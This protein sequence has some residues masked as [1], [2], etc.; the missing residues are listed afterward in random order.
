MHLNKHGD[1]GATYNYTIADFQADMQDMKIDGESV[2]GKSNPSMAVTEITN[3][4]SNNWWGY[5]YNKNTKKFRVTL[6]SFEESQWQDLKKYMEWSGNVV[7]YMGDDLSSAVVIG[8]EEKTYNISDALFA[9]F[10][11]P[12]IS[13]SSSHFNG[14]GNDSLTL[15]I[16]ATDKYYTPGQS[17]DANKIMLLVDNEV[18]DEDDGVTI[19][20]GTPEVLIGT[21]NG[22]DSQYGILQDVTITGLSQFLGRGVK[23]RLSEDTVHDLSGNKNVPK[24]ISLFNTLRVAKSSSGVYESSTTSGFLGN[25]SIQRQNIQSVTFLNST[26]TAPSTGT[27]D[28]SATEDN[29]IIAW[30]SN[31]KV[32]I[33][34]D[35]PIYANVDSSYLF[36]YIGYASGVTSGNTIENLDLLSTT[37]TTNMQYMFRG[38][39]YETMTSFA[40]GDNFETSRVTNMEGM[41]QDAGNKLTS[42]TIGQRFETSNVSNMKNMFNN[43]GSTSLTTLNLGNR[44]TTQNV[45]NMDSMFYNCGKTAMTE[46]DLGPAFTKI[47]DAHTNIFENTGK[48]GA[49]IF[50]GSAIYLNKKAFRLNANST[51]TTGY[52]VGTVVPKYK[53]IWSKTDVTFDESEKSLT[54]KVAGQVDSS[55]YG[56][57]I[58]TVTNNLTNGTADANSTKPFNVK[59]AGQEANDI[60]KKVTMSK[61]GPSSTV[62]A[63]IILTDFEQSVLQSGKSYLE[64]S[65]KTALQIAEGTLVDAY[66][67]PNLTQSDESGTMTAI[68]IKDADSDTTSKNTNG[69]MFADFV[70]PATMYDYSK[71]TINKTSKTV[72]I[73]FSI[74]DKYFASENLGIEIGAANRMIVSMDGTDLAQTHVNMVLAKTPITESGATIGYKY[75]LTLTELEQDAI[76]VGKNYLDYSG[77]V[78]ITI[79]KGSMTDKSGNTNPTKPLSV[80]PGN[81]ILKPDENETTNIDLVNPTW[82]ADSNN[83]SFDFTTGKATVIVKATDKYFKSSTLTS[84][85]ITVYLGNTAVTSG[86]TKTVSAATALKETR[87]VNGVATEVQ[88]GN[89]YTVT[90]TGITLDSDQGKL[91]IAAGTATDTSGNTSEAKDI[92]LYNRLKS[93]STETSATSSFLGND[94]TKIPIQRQNIENVTFESYISSD[95]YN[96]TTNKITDETR[97]WDVSAAGDQ[98]IIAW[99]EETRTG[100]YIVH[101]GS[102]GGIL[103]NRT[104][105]NLFKYIGYSNKCQETQ[106]IT[107]I[108]L[109]DVSSVTSMKNMFAYTGYNAMT[110]LDLGTNFDTSK[111][112]NM[113]GMFTS[114][115]ENAMTTLNLQNKFNTAIVTDMSNM[116]ERTG[117]KNLQSLDVSKFNTSAV[118][119]M[120]YMFANT[121]AESQSFKTLDLSSFNTTGVTQMQYMFQNTGF[122]EMTSLNLGSAFNTAKVT[123]MSY[124]FNGTASSKMTKLSLEG[125]FYTTAVTN[126]TSMFQNCG[127]GSMTELDLGPAFTKISGK[128]TDIFAECGQQENIKIYVGSSIYSGQQELRLGADSSN[129]ISFTR[130]TIIPKYRPQWIALTTVPDKANS[131][132]TVTLKGTVNSTNYAG[133]NSNVTNKF[134]NT[135][136]SQI[137]VSIDGDPD[138]NSNITKT[139]SGASATPESNVQCSL[140]LTGFKGTRQASKK[141]TEWS[142]N[143]A[144]EI[145]QATLVDS[146]G[147]PNLKLE[148]DKLQDSPTGKANATGKLF[149]D[150][151]APEFTYEH[152]ETEINHK[153]KKVT[154]YFSVTDK[155]FNKI[156]E[157]KLPKLADGSYNSSSIAL[158]LLDTNTTI[159]NDAIKK[160]LTRDSEIYETINGQ[161]QKVGEKFKLVIEGLD[162][163]DG[164]YYS[165]PMAIAL[166]E[167]MAEDY[168]GTKSSAKTITIGVDDPE[169][170]TNHKNQEIVD[171]VSPIW[172]VQNMNI[173]QDA[174]GK[175]N[176]TMEL[177]GKDKYLDK[178]RSKELLTSNS[179]KVMVD[180]VDISGLATELSKSLSEPEEIT[181]GLKYTLTISNLEESYDAFI[182]ARNEGKRVYREYSGDVS[183]EIPEETL[184]DNYG[185]KSSK[186]TIGVGEI[187]TLKPEIVK[188]SSSID[189]TAKTETIVF[190]VTD[191]YYSTILDDQ[192]LLSKLHVFIDNENADAITKQITN[193]ETLTA[194]IDGVERTVGKRYTLVLSDFEQAGLQSGYQFKGLS[195]TVK[196]NVDAGIATDTKGNTSDVTT[197]QGDF[198]D[199]I[200]P[201][202]IYKYT[203]PAE[204]AKS[205]DIVFDVTDKYYSSGDLTLADLT[206]KMQN[207]T[208]L[209]NYIDMK[210]IPGAKLTLST[211]TNVVETKAMNKTV[212]GEVKTGLTNQVVGRR[213]T[214]T[215]SGLEQS[216]IATGAKYLEYS[217][218]V[219]IA[220]AAGKIKD[221]SNNG[222]LNKTLTFGIDLPDETGT[223]E[224]LDIV[225]P[226]WAVDSQTVDLDNQEA[227]IVVTATDKYFRES[228]LTNETLELWINGQQVEKN[229][230]T[231]RNLMIEKQEEMYEDWIESGNTSKHLVGVKYTIKV[232]GFDIDEGQVKIKIPAGT[233]K[234]YSG[235]QSKELEFLLYSCLK[236]TNT[237][238]SETSGF[239]G[240]TSIQRQNIESVTFV[241]GLSTANNTKWDVSAGNDGSIMAWYTTN[242]SNGA[243]D[244]Y[245]GGTAAIFANPNS[246]YLFANIGSASKCTAT[247]VIKGLDLVTTKRV[248]NMKY[249]FYNTGSNAMTKL[250]LG[251]NFN[252]ESAKDMSHMFDGCGKDNMSTLK[253]N[254]KF[255]TTQV[256]DMSYM[257]ANA[258]SKLS[259]LDVSS[260][261][262]TKVTQMQ[263]M[264]QNTGSNKLKSLNLGDNFNT[265][266][267]IDM[268]Y[269]FNGTANASSD[270]TK[271]SLGKQFYTTSVTN[272]TSMFQDCGASHMTE[273]DLGPVFTK[274]A[275]T[276]TNMFASAEKSSAMVIDAPEAIYQD[277]NNFRLGGEGSTAIAYSRG[278]INPKYRTEWAIESTTV[279][280]TTKKVEITLRGKINSQITAA[281]YPAD[282]VTGIADKS[283]IKVYIDGNELENVEASMD[284][285]DASYR[286]NDSGRIEI[287]QTIT[288]TDFE[289]TARQSG[290]SYKE[291]S[292]NITLKILQDS[293]LVDDCGD[294]TQNVVGNQNIEQTFSNIKIVDFIKP[295]LTYKYSSTDIS[296]TQKTLTVDF[297]VVDKYFA[298]SSISESDITV[299]MADTNAEPSNITKTLTKVED[300]N[301]IRDN[302]TVT[303]GAKYRLVVSGLEQAVKTADAKYKDYSGPI[304]IG[305]A[306]G[307]VKDT[308]DNEN[309]PMSITVGVDEPDKS[310]IQEKVD[311]VDPIWETKNINIDKTNKK[312]TVDLYGTDKYYRSDTLDISKI[313]VFVDGTEITNSE[314][315]KKELSEPEI[316]TETREGTTTQYGVKY[317]LTLSGWAETNQEFIASKRE[318]REY[319]GVTKIRIAENTLFDEHNANKQQEFTLGTVDFINPDIIYEYS[320][321]TIDYTNK[322]LNVVFS[323]TDK[324]Y[325][326]SASSLALSDLT[327]T[328]DGKAMTT[329]QLTASGN[330]L[331]GTA[332]DSGKGMKYTLT[333]KNL[334]QNPN[335]GMNFS[336]IVSIAIP[337][338]KFADK[339][340]N[341]NEAKTITIGV[342][343][344]ENDANHNE[345]TVVDVVDP[346]WKVG[347]VTVDE[348]NNRVVVEL[349]GSDKYLDVDNSSLVSNN[350]KVYINEEDIESTA[351]IKVNKTLSDKRVEINSETGAFEVIYTLILSNFK[352]SDEDFLSARKAE[353]RLYREY[354]GN[355][356]IEIPANQLVDTSGNKNKAET[357]DLGK[358]DNIKPDVVKVSSSVDKTNKKE[359]IVFDVVDKYLQSTVLGTT[360]AQANNNLSKLHVYVDDESAD[361]ITKKITNVE[362]KTSTIGGKTDQ[363]VGYRYTLEVTGFDK[364][365]N[366]K[367]YKDWSGTVSI[368][369]DEG[370][371]IDSTN[372]VNEAVTLQGDFVDFTNPY[373][374]YTHQSSDINTANKTYTMKFRIT[375]K[376]YTSGKLTLDNLTV[377]IK[378]GQLKNGSEIEYNL[379]ELAK[380]GTVTMSLSS[381]ELNATNV[382][383]TNATTGEIENVETTP[384]GHE[385]TLI[386]SNLEK[387][388]IEEGMTTADYSGI[389]TVGIKGDIIKDRTSGGSQNGN[390]GTSITSGIDIPG[391]TGNGT[392]VD[393]V[394]PL[395]TGTGTVADPAQGTATLNF[396]ATDTYFKSSSITATNIKVFVNGEEKAVGVASGD[397]ITKTLTKADLPLETRIEN[398]KTTSRKYGET[399]T[400]NITGYPSNINQLKVIIPAGLVEDNYDNSNKEKVFNL[401]NTLKEAEPNASETSAFLGNTYGIQR[402]KI[403]QI[404]FESYI[405]GET[406]KRWDV[407][408]QQDGSIMA[409]YNTSEISNGTY[410]IHIGSDTLIGAN[411]NSSNWFSY[412]GKNTACTATNEESNPIIKNISSVRFASVKNMSNMFAYLGYSNMTTFSL[413]N[414]FFTTKAENMSGMFSNTGFSKMQSINLGTNFNTS[415]VQ[416][417]TSMFERTGYTAMTSLNLGSKFIINTENSVVMNNMFAE[418]GYTN[419]TSLT[420]GTQFNT[421]TVTS[422]KGMFKSTGN[423][424][425]TSLDLGDLFYTTNVTDMTD[426]FNGCGQDLMATLDLGPAFTKIAESNTN[427][428]TNLGKSGCVVYAPEAIYQDTKNFRLGGAGSTA[429]AYSKTIEPKYRTEWKLKTTTFDKATESLTV[430][431]TGSTNSALATTEYKSNVSTGIT[432]KAKVKVFID[433]TE[434][435]GLNMELTA[436]QVDNTTKGTKDVEQT[437]KITN[438]GNNSGNITLKV[439]QDSGLKDAYGIGSQNIE[440]SFTTTVTDKNT[441]GRLF[442]D[443]VKPE[444]KYV[445]APANID[446]TN[447]TLTV[448]FSVTDKYFASSTLITNTNG[449]LTANQT[450]VNKIT[451]AMKDNANSAVNS[452]VTKKITEI[453]P[454]QGTVDGKTVTTGYKFKLVI[455]GL[456]QE[457]SNGNYRDYS[458][459]MSISFPAGIGTDKSTNTSE[460]K[461]ITIGV[462]TD[463]SGNQ[464]NVDVVDPVWKTDNFSIDNTNKKITVDLIG[465]DKYI[466]TENSNLTTNDITVTVDGEEASSIKKEL[467]A[468]STVSYGIKYTLTLSGWEQSSLQD[469]KKFLEWSGTT[470]IKIASGTLRDLPQQDLPNT[471]TKKYNTSKE[472]TFTLG[473]VDFIKPKIEIASATKNATAGTE[474]IVINA[475]DK[476]IDT[477]NS[478]LTVEDISVYVDNVS[479]TGLTK[480]LTKGTDLTAT[481][482]GNT[483]TIGQQYTLVLSNFKQTRTSIDSAKNYSEWSGTVSIDVAEGKIKDTNNTPNVN[484]KIDKLAVDFVDFI[485]PEI[486][487]KY[488]ASDIDYGNKTFTM[489]FEITDKYFST[490]TELTTANIGQYITILVDGVD[491]TSKVTKEIVSSSD[492]TAGTTAKPINK[493]IDGV[494]K[495][496]L[497]NQVIGKHYKLKISN[498]QQAIK[499]GNTLDYSGVITVQFKAG[500]LKDTTQNSNA[501]TTLTSGVNLPGGSGNGTIVD[502]VDPMWEQIGRATVE[503]GQGKANMVIRG[504]DKYLNKLQSTL[505]VNNV[506]VRVNGEAPKTDVKLTMTEDTS[507]NLEYAKQYNVSLTGF[508]PAAYQVSFTIPAGVLMDNYGN[509][510]EEREFILFSSLKETSTETEATSPFLGNTALQRQNVEQVIFEEYIKDGD[511]T[512]WD[513]SATQDRTIL[514]WYEKNNTTGKYIVHIGTTIIMNGNVNSTNLFNYIGYSSGCATTSE[515]SNKIIKNLDLLH[516]D[517]VKYMTNMFAH[518]GYKSMQTF[519]LGNSFDTSKAESM[520]GMFNETGFEQ[521]TS[522]NLGAKFNTGSV[523]N[524]NSMFASTGHNK[525]QILSLGEPFDTSS[526]TTMNNMFANTGFAKMT[527]LDLGPNFNTSNVQSM[528][529]MFLSTGHNSMTS[530]D[531]GDKFYTTAVTDMTRMFNGTGASA[532]TTLD[533]G[534]VFTKIADTH[535]EMFTNCGVS[536]LV[537]YAPELIYSNETSFKLGR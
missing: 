162:Q 60:T 232:S 98:S 133:Y 386:I 401:F 257:F 193:V 279:D 491:A 85:N 376:Y 164:I 395:I 515:A 471:V 314:T 61:T 489:D 107:N 430:T 397:G 4:S 466:D 136:T 10:I 104:S 83:I 349:I 358:I 111:V 120:S 469:G 285:G 259:T 262:T 27:W 331:T 230:T 524:M 310:G 217:G 522:I 250:D 435:T 145:A 445:Y 14:E 286:G 177:I 16:Q 167:G 497:T 135:T 433:G 317:T 255:K 276:N 454:V 153:S 462:N 487:Y 532:M 333:I 92:V 211:P 226:V 15:K 222:N 7:F 261:D 428:A 533:L 380:A 410:I 159:P 30:Y 63:N 35:Y 271:I 252:T 118:T 529:S 437:I 88:Y 432:D 40:L 169:N 184:I 537:V 474:T 84:D 67:N 463:G 210:N 460:A 26:A 287:L 155:Y 424:K 393:V 403:S 79:P 336:G 465:T 254:D 117:Y 472:Q 343:S 144:L 385:Y 172:T 126:M 186:L 209:G 442:A 50:A 12:E 31:S 367:G 56:D 224:T 197:L 90:V 443:Y 233:I 494:V 55:T 176:A 2:L 72:T 396:T 356:K 13:V 417:M 407:S 308:S 137:K 402:G 335:N 43:F 292:G 423:K 189:K 359:T 241:S 101:I 377:K 270:I 370:I 528:N 264:F 295:E 418:C 150:S 272:M 273:L 32:Y 372:N 157:E 277:S 78:I 235:N 447:K 142:G 332:L 65:G 29:S 429:I 268:S 69:K 36:S 404:V 19:S 519:S 76:A 344:P 361:N 22:S 419:M 181:N 291:W 246:S 221:T 508:D 479:A 198:V 513:V 199:F 258:G 115:G 298:S 326:A 93:A 312:V 307:K 434:V 318:Y 527:K 247:E 58:K 175:T 71:T 122:T 525:M 66:G 206:I 482:N 475:I 73:E 476:Y 68:E 283:K 464:V 105:D 200:E 455:S 245:I 365:K 511:S 324:N 166:P 384:I 485:K 54:I 297:L 490:I 143:I 514:A 306:G 360:V 388:Q 347:E 119:D 80:G 57:A 161:N 227:T 49:N 59:V 375:D 510:S 130:G 204:G 421:T 505:N 52:T 512:L 408:A 431:L 100:V 274:I 304:T 174:S 194:T 354:S 496:G 39:G 240:N 106:V 300:V 190:D 95:I 96:H 265:A 97:A 23:L 334:Q 24:D 502:V 196:V 82:T 451:I 341:K 461:T 313:Q 483:Q 182:S 390:V 290:K 275:G 379:S 267:V 488:L 203:K 406:N 438:F 280:K 500:I 112:T 163:G 534:A 244:V 192:T 373:L 399:Y 215:I 414:N 138:A 46:L 134:S 337:K 195:G 392:V 116:F 70:R 517:N 17:L 480:K 187:D 330:S 89:Q 473:H 364:G 294:D 129:K 94:Q 48:S 87:L 329:A 128:N 44:F 114:T 387:L 426:M 296:Y 282:M 501:S 484:D 53:P 179:I 495:T 9:D 152:A 165:G 216:Q 351:G 8:E 416:N 535:D 420:L 450:E 18:K 173:T 223:K 91:R 219:T 38:L 498:L 288:L 315:V 205:V 477:A 342:D 228:T 75:E 218:N 20:Y 148:E 147:N 348:I 108:K 309:E 322:I 33:A 425:L 409:W 234:D 493:T 311:V 382:K 238:T 127:M 374:E 440:Q 509:T 278:T 458:G 449:T 225:S 299:T 350:V 345:G 178:E 536:S 481:V 34:S 47:A 383:M 201:T 446:K 160:T 253:L 185:N 158:Q 42:F 346:I 170:D 363:T 518:M 21:R 340:G 102:E 478:S 243:L 212:N 323:V 242:S 236:A 266:R 51:T 302:Q 357:L 251:T 103:A 6:S 506:I 412:I 368:N 413:G 64:W 327:V 202:I 220:T 411:E 74:T 400:L 168:S 131:E 154:V 156:D 139:I 263:Y 237:E 499:T 180:G 470:K 394:D 381:V 260:F 37:F 149:L 125:N 486:T 208:N 398:G 328:V 141:Y 366:S 110:S 99:Y 459:P 453:T 207:G 452:K 507:V 427:F 86:I 339:S 146:Y 468:K 301:E 405:G 439:L 183:I 124:M 352:E 77:P 362:K 436:R 284:I 256:T 1:G 371:G 41:F 11:K 132:I 5:W 355:A 248:T 456:Q 239:L 503:A 444:I 113:A 151:I 523:K 369:V 338:D 521:M 457:T 121:G 520:E 281:E 62:S 229:G 441:A 316:L 45:T 391:G 530:L 467:S 269:M 249:M 303:I 422:M 123:N 305:I 231:G 415:K 28:V 325:N 353:T 389:I 320:N 214:L 293:G 3:S 109:L 289:E 171:V 321:T 492:V 531:L 191:K 516:V 319:S 378:N 188:V 140:K 81:N 448:E 504:T 25:S 526:V 213:Y